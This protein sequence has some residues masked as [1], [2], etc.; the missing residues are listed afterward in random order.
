MFWRVEPSMTWDI[1]KSNETKLQKPWSGN[2]KGSRPPGALW[3][4]NVYQGIPPKY[5]GLGAKE[6]SSSLNDGLIFQMR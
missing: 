3:R 1:L 2:F 4:I 5:E 6:G